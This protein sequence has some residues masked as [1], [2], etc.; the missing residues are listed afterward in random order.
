MVNTDMFSGTC[1]IRLVFQ[2]LV[3]NF[4]GSWATDNFIFLTVKAEHTLDSGIYPQRRHFNTFLDV[5]WC[6]RMV[7][8]GEGDEEKGNAW[9]AMGDAWCCAVH[10]H[11]VECVLVRRIWVSSTTQCRRS[12]LSPFGECDDLGI[13]SS[14]LMVP[15]FCSVS[16]FC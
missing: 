8:D 16:S 12:A 14:L 9:H 4:L 6:E 1:F 10:R 2:W 13:S 7:G 3:L 5:R 11:R 15:D